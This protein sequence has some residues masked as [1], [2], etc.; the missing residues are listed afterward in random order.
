MRFISY[1]ALILAII[2]LLFSYEAFRRTGGEV[3]VME[4]YENM[5][6]DMEKM[7]EDISRLLKKSGEALE[8]K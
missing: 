3:K 1:L 7:R 2:A 4:R 5:R 8:K 6:K